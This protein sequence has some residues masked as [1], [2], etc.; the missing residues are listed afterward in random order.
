MKRQ[1]PSPVASDSVSEHLVRGAV[2]LIAAGSAVALWGSV[3]PV[4]LA[5]LAVS[6]LAWRGC[7]TCWT[8]GLLRTLAEARTS[9]GDCDGE[10]RC[11]RAP[12]DG[13]T[14]GQV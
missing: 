14:R 6:A 3:G 7:P 2:G 12:R 9:R 10:W 8:V 5:L 11:R 4:S 13:G 1:T